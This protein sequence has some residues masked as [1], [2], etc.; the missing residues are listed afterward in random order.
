MKKLLLAAA[1]AA[2]PVA[3][4]AA[5][6]SHVTDLARK[7][8]DKG[9]GATCSLEMKPVDRGGYFPCLDFGPYRLVF[10]Y[11][12]VKGFVVQTGR[13]PFPILSGPADDPEFTR[14]GPWTTDMPARLAMWWNDV[15]E[16]GA[17]R[18][19]DQQKRSEEERAAQDY[20]SKLMG[21]DAQKPAEQPPVAAQAASDQSPSSISPAGD[22]SPIG[23]DIKQILAH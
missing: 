2:F 17:D 15:V 16:G 9:Y 23:D 11:G 10:S 20:V 21:K 14:Q 6:E 22:V 1:L 3:T 12:T 5:G 13:A 19:A 8:V 4:H 18:Q 7:A